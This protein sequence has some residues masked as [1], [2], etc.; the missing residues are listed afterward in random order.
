MK[1]LGRL[2][3]C[4]FAL[5]SFAHAQTATQTQSLI[6]N[7]FQ[8]AGQSPIANQSLQNLLQTLFGYSTTAATSGTINTPG[9]ADGIYNLNASTLLHW[10]KAIA[11]VRQGTGR[12]RVVIESDSTGMGQGA[13]TGGSGNL[14]GAYPFA[15]P[16]VLAPILSKT[17]PTVAQSFFGDQ[18]AVVA[19]GTYDT[20]V[21]LGA[22]WIQS[23]LSTLG[24]FFF[25]YQ[26]GAVNNL[27]FNPG[28]SFDRFVIYYAVST[29]LG[30]AT[31]NVDGGASL[32]TLTGAGT[33]ALA[34]SGVQSVT[35]GTHTINIVPSNTG[36]FYVAGILTW[37]STTPAVDVIQTAYSGGTVSAFIG[38]GNPWSGIPA[39]QILA[40]D[41]TI[42]ALTVNDSNSLTNLGAYASGLQTIVTAAK[43]S[44]D[45]LLMAGPPSNTTQATN[46]TLSQYIQAGQ[47]VA[48]ANNCAYLD[49]P[50][51]WTSYA[52]TNPVLPYFDA[53]HPMS[54]GY[55]DMA[56]AVS[57]MV[58]N[59]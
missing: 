37:T 4:L 34:N 31:F 35:A 33:L 10:R 59:P 27:T 15:W 41:L 44:G 40:P 47:A 52:Y 54:L 17:I 13:G 38:A 18:H 48:A 14:N 25:Q 6:T 9:T 32:G 20:R 2:L 45:C 28:V 36:S 24:G 29:G 58:N 30:N 55:L 1:K 3:L 11:G 49:I 43:I 16:Q 39:L 26:T 57:K 23:T 5:S 56:Q 53:L 19:Y 46:G 42:V 21:G 7:T 50:Q 8:N 22:N 51:R 12:G